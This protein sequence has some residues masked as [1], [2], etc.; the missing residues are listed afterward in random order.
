MN[1]YPNPLVSVLITTYNCQSTIIST[2]LSI[3]NQTFKD[4][5][6]VIIDD[7]STD[8]TCKLIDDFKKKHL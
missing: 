4:F 8:K 2:L 5:E 7:G 6:I 1:N 3:C